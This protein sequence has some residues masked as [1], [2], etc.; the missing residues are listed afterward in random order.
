MS[1]E[2]AETIKAILPSII[3]IMQILGG[4][5]TVFT[6]AT[7]TMQ[8]SNSQNPAPLLLR[9]FLILPV[10]FIPTYLPALMGIEL[11]NRVRQPNLPEPPIG[12][13]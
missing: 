3:I 4:M 8:L 13:H 7:V 6:I 10:I 11:D 9:L 1:T 12:G 5:I 2:I